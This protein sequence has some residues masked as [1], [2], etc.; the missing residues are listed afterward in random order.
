VLVV[1]FVNSIGVIREAFSTFYGTTTFCSG[2][3]VYNPGSHVDR[4]RLGVETAC[5][6]VRAQRVDSACALPPERAS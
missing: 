6:C 4:F 1:D 5:C 2:E 3:H